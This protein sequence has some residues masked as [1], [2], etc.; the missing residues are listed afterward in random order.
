MQPLKPFTV[1]EE[2]NQYA[3]TIQGL[4]NQP[5]TSLALL[6]QAERYLNKNSFLLKFDIKPSLDEIVRRLVNGYPR[7]AI[8]GGSL[9]H[10]AHLLDTDHILK[11]ACRIWQNGG[12]PFTFS[13]PVICDGTAQNNIGQSYSLV[14]RNNTASAINITFEGHGYHAA[15]VLSGCDKS[16]AGILS[17]LAAAD[18][19]RMSKSR[20]SSPVWSVFVPAHVLK[21]GV[22]PDNVK[23]KLYNL[24][25]VFKD[26]NQPELAHDLEDNIKYILQ[27]SSDEAFSGIFSRAVKLSLM[28]ADESRDLLNQLAV[29]TCHKNGGVCAF[30]GTGN[31][32]RTMVAALG[33]VPEGLELLTGLPNDEQV[34]IGV[35][36]LFNILN[37]EEYR[38]TN[39]LK[40]NFVNVFVAHNAT[41]SSSNLM[42]HLP[43]IMQYAGFDISLNDYKTIKYSRNIPEIF[44]HSLTEGRDTFVFAEQ[45]LKNQH[46]GLASIYKVLHSLDVKMN[47]NAPTVQG[48]TWQ[49]IID[50]LPFVTSGE[51]NDNENLIKQT[52]ISQKSGVEVL[53][54]NFFNSAVIKISGMHQKQID[55]FNN[56]YFIVKYYENEHLCNADFANPDLLNV[57]QSELNINEQLLQQLNKYNN[58]DYQSGDSLTD[59]IKKQTLSFAFIIGGQ[60][61]KAYGMPEMF[62]PSQNLRHHSLLEPSSILMTDGRYSGVTKGACIGHTSPEAFSNGDIGYLL[63]GDILHM[64]LQNNQLNIIDVDKFIADDLTPVQSFT[65]NPKRVQ[66]Q[67]ERSQRMLE[68]RFDIATSN[69]LTYTTDAETGV[70]P[71]EV[72]ERATVKIDL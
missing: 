33:L 50:Q 24:A 43:A 2:D 13:F 41:G 17:G 62:S 32:S 22:I 70:V 14:S 47:L 27:C 56:R 45:Y 58:S 46:Y 64:N 42:L 38:V 51:L 71:L 69:L 66:L 36:S 68:R 40:E 31:S 11:A 10:P 37:K 57:L 20:G 7:I 55:N 30:N 49:Q 5:I 48:K 39:I 1:N 63:N 16:P 28:S 67:Q 25:Q 6:N 44:A 18:R 54:G 12:V 15:Y 4:A 61:P 3:N 9:D 65:E 8:I 19:A 35:D 52:P 59:A 29:H 34:C 26:K 23:E 53:S 60:G 72:N 21:G